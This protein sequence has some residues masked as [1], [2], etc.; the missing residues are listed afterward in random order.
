M[1]NT[2]IV[3]G[4]SRGIG[5]A[6]A[7]AL[8]RDGYQIVLN[9]RA[10]DDAA[11]EAVEACR[12][13]GAAAVP[14]KADVSQRAGV[15]RLVD[16]ALGRFGAIH[17]LV[18]NAGRNID[19]PFLEMSDED[20]RTVLETNL[21]SAFMCAQAAARSMVAGDGGVIINIGSTTAIRGRANG[22]NYCA[23][24]AGLLTLTKCLALELAP[25]VRVNCVIPGSVDS[26][27]GDPARLAR[28]LGTVPLGRM[29]T[30]EDVAQAV[31]YLV[32]ARA[33]YVTGQKVIVDGGQFMY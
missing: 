24:K 18:N 26:G 19:R 29:G 11:A 3:T 33:A 9:Y 1:P 16:E 20:W 30:P 12:S 2:A 13:A 21:S 15:D 25:K 10:D 8:A 31:S 28:V 32:S 27:A 17:V 6:I 22:A 5:R 7:C 23:A 4:G 14:V